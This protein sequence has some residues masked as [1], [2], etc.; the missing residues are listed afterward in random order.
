MPDAEAM[1]DIFAEPASHTAAKTP[2]ARATDLSGALVLK[3][4]D[5]FLLTD[6]RG[7]IELDHRGLGLY[8]GDT[9][10]LSL[11]ELR[12]NGVRPVVLRTGTAVGYH[13]TLQLTNPDLV[14]RAA[15]MDASEIVLR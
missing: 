4:D 13:S 2:V 11:F 5:L 10:F 3:H 1:D 8:A 7:D 14:E 15:D 12:V 6:A 9:R